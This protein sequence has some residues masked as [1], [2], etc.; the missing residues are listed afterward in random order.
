MGPIQGVQPKP[1]DAPTIN[2]KTN[3]KVSDKKLSYKEIYVDN[4]S[5][6]DRNQAINDFQ[7][8]EGPSILISPSITEGLADSSLPTSLVY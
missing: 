1:K 8:N 4:Y 7:E 5:S 2:G 3:D 6:I